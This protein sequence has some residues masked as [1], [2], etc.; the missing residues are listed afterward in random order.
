[1]M[2]YSRP[3]VN[4]VLVTGGAGYVGTHV[5]N[6]LRER[7]IVYDALLYTNEYLK[8]GPFVYGDVTDY[9]RL[10][11]LLREVDCVVWL[12][13]IVGDAACMVNPRKAIATNQEA[14]QFLVEN[15]DGPIIFP[16]S[17]SV[18]G[19]NEGVAIES[20]ELA[21]LSLYAQTKIEAEKYLVGKN[22]LVLRLG[23]LHG[24]SERM[25]F[26][27]VVN[28]M[29]MNAH[30]RGHIEVFGGKQYRPLLSVKDVAAFIASMVDQ[31]WTPGV[32]N[33]ATEN[34]TVLEVAQI[35]QQE[36]GNVEIETVQTS[37]EDSRNYRVNFSKANTVLG[38]TGQ[39]TTRHSVRE[40]SDLV[41][42]G[43]IKDF[44]D[45]KYANLAALNGL[46]QRSPQ[47]Q[48]ASV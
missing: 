33:L 45:L 27:L 10:K 29:T 26:D 40:L 6:M 21:P 22:A 37:F 28:V 2:N 31:D 14:V 47:W 41:R 42:S 39:H 23:T 3:A 1:M 12:A 36:L 7:C 17:C 18:Y 43:R 24:V 44:S 38:F 48:T 35:V 25:R 15:F 4:R 5:V 20:D 30:V 19:I 32:Y 11:P 16:S 9:K 46:K 13:A 34:L 8:P